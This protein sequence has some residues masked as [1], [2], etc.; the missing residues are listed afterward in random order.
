MNKRHRTRSLL[1]FGHFG[2]L[3]YS[4]LVYVLYCISIDHYLVFKSGSVLFSKTNTLKMLKTHL[5][6]T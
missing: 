5:L 6:I 1:C 4:L 2:E 3:V